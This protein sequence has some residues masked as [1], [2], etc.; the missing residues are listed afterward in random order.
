MRS[1][2]RND[3]RHSNIHIIRNRI[4]IFRYAIAAALITGAAFPAFSAEKPVESLDTLT[5]ER[6]FTEMPLRSLDLL[7]RSS[8]LDMLDY[9]KADSLVTVANTMGGESRIEKAGKDYLKIRLTPVSTLEIALLPYR[10][11]KSPKIAMAIYTIGSEEEAPDSDIA[12]YDTEMKPIDRKH[13]FRQP[14]LKEFF[15]FPKG[16]TTSMKEIEEMIPF[17]AASYSLVPSSTST[18]DS[19]SFTLTGKLTVNSVMA[20]EERNL[21]ELFMRPELNWTWN[22]REWKK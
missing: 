9:L 12:F 21:I 17:P 16:A 2:T 3:S 19:G 8:R 13:L 18:A 6:A 22:G 7:T 15:S 14:D 1:S 11:P 4:M 10:D 5:I 20:Q